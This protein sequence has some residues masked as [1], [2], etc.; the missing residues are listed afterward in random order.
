MT[1]PGQLTQESIQAMIDTIQ[2]CFKQARP[3][4]LENAGTTRFTSKQDGSPVTGTDVEVEKIVTDAMVQKFP[5]VPVYGEESGYADDLPAVC[6]L[7]D[8]VDGTDSLIKNLPFFTCMAVLITDNEATAC[9]VYNPTT[10]DMFTAQKGLG[11]YKNGKRLDLSTIPLP[12][13][14]NCK[15]RHIAHLN[16]ILEPSGVSCVVAPSG[17][18]FG[19][20]A[21]AEGSSAARFQLHSRGYSHDYA[22]GALLVREAGGCIVT[23]KEDT[24]PY[25]LRSFVAC[26]PQLETVLQENIGIIRGLEI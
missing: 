5:S 3:L 24:H 13:E 15:G 8:P 22:P 14:A 21:V 10:Q 26:H 17:A 12:L 6:W 19:F 2:L 1:T 11:A 23:L 9:V 25:T 20:A 7:I 18:G 4:I 16:K